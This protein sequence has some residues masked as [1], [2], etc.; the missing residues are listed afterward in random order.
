MLVRVA[1]CSAVLAVSTLGR[2][3]LAADEL[4]PLAVLSLASTGELKQDAADIGALL[5]NPAFATGLGQALRGRTGIERLGGWDDAR[6]WGAIV[7]TDGLAV[8]PLAVLPVNDFDAWLQSLAPVA[9]PAE[10]VEG[11]P[12]A[13]RLGRGEATFY[14][15]AR[16]GWVFLAQ[17]PGD[18]ARL[19][20]PAALDLPAGDGPDG[21]LTIYPQ[22]LPEAYRTMALDYLRAAGRAAAAT[23]AGEDRAHRRATG[24]MALSLVE[25]GLDEVA[26]MTLSW[27]LE[28]VDRRGEV[29]LSIEPR[30]ESSLARQI[31]AL[32]EQRAASAWADDPAV[33]LA[34][35]WSGP[36]R[37]IAA[38]DRSGPAYELD[39]AIG[40][41]RRRWGIPLAP[42]LGDLAAKQEGELAVLRT[43]AGLTLALSQSAGTLTEESLGEQLA[44]LGATEAPLRAEEPR[45]RQWI[46][47]VERVEELPEALAARLG[48]EPAWHVAL[49]GKRMVVAIGPTADEALRS[50]LDGPRQEGPP[51]AATVRLAHL[52]GLA[53][54]SATD[55]GQQAIM[56]YVAVALAAGDDALRIKGEAR[57]GRLELHAT[58][59]DSVVRAGAVGLSLGLLELLR[60]AR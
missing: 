5:N 43:D 21:A 18:L 28:P 6:R 10:P 3:A 22:R 54:E 42:A 52:V 31:D 1:L 46:V 49:G 30:A 2:S 44:P 39:A 55:G 14:A 8:V 36:S 38:G 40:D 12:G 56:A 4:Q 47:P 33:L 59:G 58:A 20:D 50:A 48:P 9:G 51:L 16:D 60:S 29:R 15:A 34:A 13:V 53:A 19:P 17:A 37:E 57:D 41:A 7:E 35:A 23:D 32:A 26:Q 25:R 24:M 45:G 27:T 11:A